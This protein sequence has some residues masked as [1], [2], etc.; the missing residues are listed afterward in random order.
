MEDPVKNKKKRGLITGLLG[1]GVLL[2]GMLLG[3]LITKA[4]YHRYNNA[5][6]QKIVDTYYLMRD[7]WWFAQDYE[8]IDEYLTDLAVNGLTTSNKDMFT[9]YTN[10]LEEQGLNVVN[11]GIGI[12]HSYY[13]GNRRIETVYPNSPAYKAGLKEG[14]V[15]LGIYDSDTSELVR[16]ENLSFEESTELMANHKADIISFEIEGKSQPVEIKKDLF[17]QYAL[18]GDY[19]KKNGEVLV[20]LKIDNFLD[21]ALVEDFSTYLDEVIEK[22][23][24]IDKL[25][26]DLRNNGG[27]YVDLAM[28]LSSL[29]VPKNSTIVKIEYPNGQKNTYINHREPAYQN[30]K[31]INLIQNDGTA[32]ASEMFILALKDNLPTSQVD[33]IGSKSYGKGIMQNVM[34]NKDGSV[35]RYTSARTL[36]PKDYSIHGVGI[37]PT[38]EMK[39]QDEMRNYYGEVSFLTKEVK[40]H[41][42]AQ[43]NLVM[44]ASYENF[45]EALEAYCTANG[46]DNK[47]FTYQVGRLLQKQAYDLY[48]E[49]EDQVY[50]RA[51]EA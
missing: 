36:S 37:E 46:F 40:T 18:T 10:S 33:V 49:Y 43:I 29:F 6:I 19:S 48:L 7:E 39:I 45:D 27:G 21:R 32:S 13:G 25:V 41:I 30:I 47:I 42:L 1:V 12:S 23:G 51:L 9:F 26:I 31:K 20:S 14:D 35:I 5:Y 17:T 11:K 2:V 16:F 28:N 38:I 15:L 24:K 8:N 3:G 34:E 22:E 50:A 4:T 44:N